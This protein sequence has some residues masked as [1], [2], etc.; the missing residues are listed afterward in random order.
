VL[1][2]AGGFFIPLFFVLLGAS[3]DLRGLVQHPST[4]ELAIA[5]ALLTVAVHVIGALIT[6]QPPAAGFVACAQLGVPSAIVALGLSEHVV[7]TTQ[8]A[9]I[10]TASV[11]SLAVCTGGAALLGREHP[12]TTVPEAD[13]SRG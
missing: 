1:G 10:V 13:A 7:T 5:L 11:I 9:A 3:I 8:G 2:I 6:R 4:G 12:S